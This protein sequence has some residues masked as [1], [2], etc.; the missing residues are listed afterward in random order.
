MTR[1]KQRQLRRWWNAQRREDGLKSWTQL[2]PFH[3]HLSR[4]S[5]LHCGFG[6]RAH[7]TDTRTHVK[8]RRSGPAVV[9]SQ[10]AS[11]KDRT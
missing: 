6:S 3:G 11:S 4:V 1:T 8:K 7:A 5:A 9:I 2:V 10:R